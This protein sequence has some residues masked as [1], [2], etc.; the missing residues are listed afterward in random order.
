MTISGNARVAGVIG[1]PVSHS[2]SPA[3]HGFWL[4]EHGI[5]GAYIPLPIAP[6]NLEPALRALPM[7]GFAG[8]NVTV[9]HKEAAALIVDELDPAARRLGAVNTIIC[10]PDGRLTGRNTDGY[11]FIENLRNSGAGWLKSTGPAVVIGAG[12][13]ARAVV[14]A[15]LDDGC[16]ELRLVNRTM[17]RAEKLAADLAKDPEIGGK[18]KPVAWDQRAEIL[19]DADLLVNCSTLGMVGQPP[20][21][22]CLDELPLS[23]LVNDIVY[24]PLMTP[25]LDA[26]K[27]RGNPVVDGLGMLLHQG[28]P[29]FAAWFGV[30]PAV[31]DGLRE[32]MLEEIRGG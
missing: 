22:I 11:G 3:L 6:D 24:T 13:A 19:A 16:P 21:D 20:L 9:P 29:G 27:A 15:L 32:L 4:R 10:R 25:L 30:E 28:R 31:T 12:G 1:W 23:A 18:I 2:R 7:L 17:A 26:A 14:A 8:V 5:D